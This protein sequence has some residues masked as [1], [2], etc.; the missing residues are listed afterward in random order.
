MREASN[1]Q[2][3]IAV[4][5]SRNSRSGSAA[6]RAFRQNSA[7]SS[8]AASLRRTR[9]GENAHSF[10]YVR[11]ACCV[12]QNGEGRR[13]AARL[14]FTRGS[15]AEG[16][17]GWKEG[18][19]KGKRESREGVGRCFQL[20]VRTERTRETDKKRYTRAR[21]QETKRVERGPRRRFD[22]ALL[23]PPLSHD[24]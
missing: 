11:R 20:L 15:R 22:R 19:R 9:I 16:D 21:K 23:S 7:S 1:P 17:E 5:S 10:T 18:E 2:T 4:L 12:Y 6:P 24:D 13:G 14:V 3:G 8:S